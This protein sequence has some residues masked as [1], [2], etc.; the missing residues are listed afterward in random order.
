MCTLYTSWNFWDFLQFRFILACLVIENGNAHT[1]L[2]REH[3]C[4]SIR[5][6]RSCLGCSSRPFTGKL[7]SFLYPVRMTCRLLHSAS[8]KR[9]VW[10]S[11]WLSYGSSRLESDAAT[12]MGI[13]SVIYVQQIP[14]SHKSSR[15]HSATHN[16]VW[17]HAQAV[18]FLYYL[19]KWIDFAYCLTEWLLKSP[20]NFSIV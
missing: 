15:W 12:N 11:V 13:A 1:D 9:K 20:F 6:I 17:F 19:F 18:Y 3:V 8:S 4:K 14:V 10:V 5:K 7:F 16:T 2:L